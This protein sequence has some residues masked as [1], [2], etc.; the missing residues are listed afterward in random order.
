MLVIPFTASSVRALEQEVDKLK[1]EA[2]D[3][4][5]RLQTRQVELTDTSSSLQD[6]LEK[7]EQFE[8][9]LLSKENHTATLTERLKVHMC[10]YV[11][12]SEHSLCHMVTDDH[13]WLTK[14]VSFPYNL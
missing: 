2:Q 14:L 7:L 13:M 4:G 6:Q 11:H 12:F 5:H 1:E 10:G 9:L 8:Q 3:L